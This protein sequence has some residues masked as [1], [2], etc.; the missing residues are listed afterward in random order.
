MQSLCKSKKQID[1]GKSV[2]AGAA[3]RDSQ[4]QLWASQS[5]EVIGKGPFVFLESRTGKGLL[6]ILHGRSGMGE[7]PRLLTSNLDNRVLE[8]RLLQGKDHLG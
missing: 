3:V 8:H 1:I 7:E 6:E 2:W 4:E 5:A